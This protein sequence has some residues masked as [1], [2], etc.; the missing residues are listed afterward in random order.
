[1]IFPVICP[2]CHS[3]SGRRVI[4]MSPEVESFP[5]GACHTQWSEPAPPV[6]VVP[7]QKMTLLDRLRLTVSEFAASR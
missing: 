1:M 3:D 7:A 5:C 6:A 2:T 4:P